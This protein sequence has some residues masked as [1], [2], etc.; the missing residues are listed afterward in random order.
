MVVWGWATKAELADVIG[1]IYNCDKWREQHPTECWAGWEQMKRQMDD[2]R[3]SGFGSQPWGFNGYHEG[4]YVGNEKWIARCHG[5]ILGHHVTPGTVV[6]AVVNPT[7]ANPSVSDDTMGTPLGGERGSLPGSVGDTEKPTGVTTARKTVTW[8]DLRM[9][10]DT[11]PMGEKNVIRGRVCI[12]KDGGSGAALPTIRGRIGGKRLMLT[13]DTCVTISILDEAT[14]R[15]IQWADG[16]IAR[17]PWCGRIACIGGRVLAMG[18][19]RMKAHICGQK[20]Q[21]DF[22][23][24][25]GCPVQALIGLDLLWKVGAELSMAKGCVRCGDWKRDFI[26]PTNDD[27]KATLIATM[28]QHVPPGTTR[29]LTVESVSPSHAGKRVWLRWVLLPRGMAFGDPRVAQLDD[30][31]V[32]TVG[33]LNKG[34]ATLVVRAG[35]PVAVAWP[36]TVEEERMRSAE[37]A[38]TAQA[39]PPMLLKLRDPYDEIAPEERVNQLFITTVQTDEAEWKTASITW[40]N[41]TEGQRAALTQLQTEFSDLFTNDRAKPGR[42]TLLE[43]HIP[44]KPCRTM[45]RPEKVMSPKEKEM[46]GEEIDTMRRLGVI[47]EGPGNGRGFVPDFAIVAVPLR[48]LGVKGAPWVWD[49]RCEEAF[50]HIKHLIAEKLLLEYPDYSSEFRREIHMDASKVGMGAVLVQM[51]AKGGE[52][53]IELASRVT[54]PHE[55]KYDTMCE[56]EAAAVVWALKKFRSYI[57][58]VG[59]VVK[60][61]NK[62]LTRMQNQ[63]HPCARV[64][65][66]Q[67]LLDDYGAGGN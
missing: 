59:C 4:G 37:Q 60:T 13:L 49:E 21:H 1:T 6:L 63:E 50:T 19:A 43:H 46:V 24:I 30:L 40:E 29:R 18:R 16:D 11:H 22:I 5:E 51:D 66:W 42:T 38:D 52:R 47:K 25:Q 53:I 2:M 34:S 28:D 20:I 32:V 17:E 55:K 64:A 9:D 14:F 31:R 44:I 8:A 26:N 15:W 58:G 65:R 10:T 45:C 56:L 54:T 27:G 61:D 7:L 36:V 57:H 39:I 48:E 3:V 12:F 33:L 23:I 67:M 62:A 35:Q 41:L